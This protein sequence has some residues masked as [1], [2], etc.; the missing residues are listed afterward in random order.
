MSGF[1]V[2]VIGGG[3][4][5]TSAAAFLAE[6]GLSV[7]VYERAEIA[8]GASGRNSGAIQHPFDGP[9]GSLHQETL[10][11]YREVSAE[12][13]FAMP[14]S[15]AGLLI[16][17]D[18]E[19]ALADVVA[20][21]AS[22]VPALKPTFVA[23]G[24]LQELEP[25]LANDV[26]ACRLETGYPV[27]PAAATHAFARRAARAGATFE[28]GVEARPESVAADLVLICAGPWTSELVPEWT[29]KPPIRSLW[30]VVV[31]IDLPDPP[32]HVIEELGIDSGHA[33]TERLFSLITAGGSTGVGSTFL[34][35]LADAEAERPELLRRA[36]RF[37]PAVSSA[38][39][40]GIRACARPL[41]F[42]GRPLIGK[43][44]G[45]ER[46]FVCAGHGPWGIST[47]PASARRVAEQ[48]LGRAEVE[49]A[50]DPAR[51]SV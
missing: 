42:D 20:T 17:G 22:A 4:V 39:T 25:A 41:S 38:A 10:Q 49:P 19:D 28:I 36:A 31:S 27:A 13:G 33:R 51:W 50:F 26:A 1:D 7:I 30:G 40:T 15:G 18:D 8:A 32:R 12:D 24:E 37:V 16:I 46:V 6:A 14:D 29:A 44:P 5:G 35:E 3:I 11:I 21:M 9:L 43:A 45:Q 34:E 2:A 48:M 23:R 47:G